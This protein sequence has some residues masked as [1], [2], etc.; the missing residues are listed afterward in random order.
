MTAVGLGIFLLRYTVTRVVERVAYYFTPGIVIALPEMIYGFKDSK[1]YIW[2][3]VL[4]T[5]LAI[6]MFIRTL[7]NSDFIPYRFFW[8]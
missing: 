1:D 6:L 7:L 4:V 3:D 2:I 8:S 5:M